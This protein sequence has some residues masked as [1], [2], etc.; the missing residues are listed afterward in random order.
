[1]YEYEMAKDLNGGYEIER[2][3]GMAARKNG[4]PATEADEIPFDL[5]G[6]EYGDEIMTGGAA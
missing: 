6:W 1:M 5:Y 4:H 3:M 2:L